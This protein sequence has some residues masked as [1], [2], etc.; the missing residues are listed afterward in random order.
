MTPRLQQ[1]YQDSV[2]PALKAEFGYTNPHQVPRILKVVVNMGLGDAVQ[3]PK[4]IEAAQTELT[5]RKS[6]V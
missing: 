6:V 4:I 5:D 3:N 2:V 1:V